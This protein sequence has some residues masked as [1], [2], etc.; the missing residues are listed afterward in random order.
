ML[1]ENE[2]PLRERSR[3]EPL[4][5]RAR[6]L[7]TAPIKIEKSVFDALD[8]ACQK[9][10]TVGPPILYR[11]D[12]A[13]HVLDVKPSNLT[14]DQ[15]YEILRCLG[16]PN[17]IK[18]LEVLKLDTATNRV[19]LELQLF[20]LNGIKQILAAPQ[21]DAK[22]IFP[23][24]GGHRLPAGPAFGQVQ[25]ESGPPPAPEGIT[26]PNVKQPVLRLAVT[27]IG[28]YSTYTLG[29]EA[30]AGVVID[31][32]FAEIRFKF[33]PGCFSVNCAPDWESLPAPPPAP[34]I[35]YLAK[36]YDSFRATLITAMA[37]RVPGWQ[38][39]SEADLDQVL[40][41]LF[42]V[43]ADE[44]SD[45]QDRVMNEA[46][47]A[48]AR[49][50]VSLARHARLMD[51]HI[52]QGN[53][54][55]AWLAL[56]VNSTAPAGGF[57]LDPGFIVWPGQ[58]DSYDQGVVFVSRDK[59]YLDRPLNRM[60]LYTWSGTI[61]A[62]AAGSTRADLRPWLPGASQAQ[63]QAAALAVQTAIR[64]GLTWCLLIQEHLNPVT[65]RPV[66]RDIGKRQ[67]LRL[68]PNAQSF[69]DPVTGEWYVSVQWNRQD[70]LRHAYCFTVD[71]TPGG[72]VDDVSLFH[73]NLIQVFHGRPRSVLFKA[74]DQWLTGPNQ[75]H[76]LPTRWGTLCPLPEG[77][78][79]YLDTPPGGE[80]PPVSTLHITVTTPTET[81]TWDEVP[82][83]IH[84][85]SDSLHFVVETDEEDRNQVRFGNGV[86]GRELPENAVVTSVYQ[87]GAGLD[88]NIGTDML[89]RFDHTTATGKLIEQSWNPFDVTSGRAPEPV[90]EIIRRVPEAYRTRQ[91]RAVTLRDYEL[92]AEELPEV[93][94]AAASY[95]WT[96]SWRTVRVAI[97]PAG[98][99]VVED[100]VR[101]KASRHLEAVRLIG[102]DLEIRPPRFVPLE[103][104]VVLCA[105][106]GYWPEDLKFVLAQ[107][108][109]TSWTRDGRM[110][111]FHPDR[112]SFGQGL[113]ASEIS[114]RA[115]AVEG[116]EHVVSITL[117]RWNDGTTG[118]HAVDRLRHNE[119]IQVLS[120]PDHME[121]GFI[122]FDV[123]G[124][125]I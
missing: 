24:T 57:D 6:S 31:P 83:L 122:D 100:S 55:G 62:L 42:A 104:H 32:L 7:Y 44:L 115:Q 121:L 108:F 119:I 12:G 56:E 112:W 69:Q 74:Q 109:S 107:E 40:L 59:Q 72:A 71:C 65:G 36:D 66:G 9:L 52:H 78:L 11:L 10:L 76:Y 33:R 67:L 16:R 49:K 86:N 25:V 27:P 123:R 14:D 70:A 20:N 23:I 89:V 98:T 50:R 45:Y 81:E 13:D 47:L 15:R 95:A 58:A 35:D 26:Q 34:A 102:E 60:G 114:G 80:T 64:N 116:I 105:S 117:K 85:D 111:F 41:E 4:E 99:N 125:Q 113:Q 124:G 22:H 48:S 39:S 73:G 96:G 120:D 84:S 75:M 28:D 46:Y 61:P 1:I 30:L 63:Q 18:R 37:A 79:A 54:A 97:D 38:P 77:A 94:R 68:L 5:E 88:G 3:Q 82:N 101:L 17:G 19:V 118:A 103:I 87:E 93:S 92:R 8:A 21:A 106:P 2:L 53:Q 29:L 90:W 110:G 51:Y 43:A 91:L